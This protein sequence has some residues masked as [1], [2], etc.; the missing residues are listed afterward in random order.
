MFETLYLRITA[1]PEHEKGNPNLITTKALTSKQSWHSAI[2][3]G[4][5]M[6]LPSIVPLLLMVLIHGSKL[7]AGGPHTELKAASSFVN[8]GCQCSSLTFKDT[9][10]KNHGNCKRSVLFMTNCYLR[11]ATG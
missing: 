11:G 9:Y 10:N 2:F 7:P 1:H 8:C 4:L 6:I 3:Q 5:M